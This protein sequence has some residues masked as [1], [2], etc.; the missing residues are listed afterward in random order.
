ML[1]DGYFTLRCAKATKL[2]GGGGHVVE[3]C[4]VEREDEQQQPAETRVSAMSWTATTAN[5]CRQ[6][7]CGAAAAARCSPLDGWKRE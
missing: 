1:P 7:F 3:R 5:N 6:A 2:D 4:R